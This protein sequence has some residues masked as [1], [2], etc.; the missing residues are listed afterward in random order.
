MIRFLTRTGN[1]NGT[2]PRVFVSCHPT[3]FNLYFRTICTDIFAVQENCAIFYEDDPT[4]IFDENELFALLGEMRLIVVPVT[5]RLLTESS[6]ALAIELPFAVR[7]NIPVL[8]IIAESDESKELV[9]A[10]NNTKIFGGM[11]FLSRYDIDPTALRYEDKLATYLNSVL[12]DEDEIKRIQDEFSSKIFLSYR[13]KDREHAQELMRKIHKVD[14]CR[15]TAIW[16]DE[17]LIP[18]E[19]FDSN[20][21][22]ALDESDIF[23][24]SV[25]SS[26]GEP[27]NYVANHE[28][29]DAVRKGKP[30]VAAD[31]K[32]FDVDSMNA[33]EAMYPG[34]KALM[35]DPDNVDH[36]GITLRRRLTEDA[37]IAENELLNDDG[38]HLYYIALAY[39]NSIRTEGDPGRAADIFRL[40]AENG[41]CEAWLRLIKMHRMGDG[42]PRNLDAALEYCCKAIAVLQ[43]L[44]GTTFRNDSV[45]A[46]VYEEEGHIHSVLN[47]KKEA[48]SAYRVAYD[49]RGRMQK[50]YED[51]STKDYCESMIAAASMLFL[52]GSFAEAEELAADF[53][54]KSGLVPECASAADA[55][56]NE[57]MGD[58]IG[59]LRISARTYSLLC[60]VFI[61][62]KKHSDVI[63]YMKARIDVCERIAAVT[64]DVSDLRMLADAC[65][66]YAD[67]LKNTDIQE[68]NAYIDKY[69]E[70][71]SQI[72]KYEERKTRTINDAIDIFSIADNTLMRIYAGDADAQEKARALY[73]EVLDNCSKLMDSGA[74]YN[75]IILSANVYKRFG[76]MER[77]INGSGRKAIEN[78]AKALSICRDAEKEY[79][80]DV[81][82]MHMTSAILDHMGTIY[83]GVDDM[84]NAT[85]CYTD[86]L[87]LDMRASRVIK[88]P[89]SKHN[90]AKS[91]M[92]CAEV[93]MRRGHQ[94]VSDVNNRSAMKI[95]SAL[96]QETDDYRIYEDLALANFRLGMSE[97]FTPEQR[98]EYCEEASRIYERLKEMTNNAEEYGSAYASVQKYKS[99]I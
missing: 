71:R 56:G 83:L 47:N 90:L 20:I 7:N 75:A 44:E 30:L 67:I 53:I 23:V 40:S 87:E 85:Q 86:A 49:L 98:L 11:Q 94:P 1:L 69:T 5:R 73:N 33:L 32:H 31:M 79:R 39:K 21:M 29:P 14:V 58:D 61:Q 96:V 41:C 50:M 12:V 36:F 15:D 17:Y 22:Q 46:S 13:K 8:P 28:Y 3:D 35:I 51:A 77:T 52:E 62:L 60:A 78:Y 82:L 66:G 63:R 4:A 42:I 34:I 57:S 72:T 80:N 19:S 6:R 81:Q 64:D 76:D 2:M 97:R 9:G 84:T 93:N 68:A 27:G 95:L 25:T 70:I 92:R 16:Y 18:G 59:M 88:D 48:F 74:R 45:L 38:E 37:G 43:P 99:N 10:F 24:M 26:F 55:N 91:Y 89:S 54:D 65:L